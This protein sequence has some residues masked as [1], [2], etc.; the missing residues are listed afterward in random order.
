MG[1][2]RMSEWIDR[3][4]ERFFIWRLKRRGDI[5]ALPHPCVA[6]PTDWARRCIDYSKAPILERTVTGAHNEVLCLWLLLYDDDDY[7]RFCLE[8]TGNSVFV[9]MS[10]GHKV[11]C[12]CRSVE[13]RHTDRFPAAYAE[14]VLDAT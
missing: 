7:E 8:F 14:F 2:D 10:H 9:V 1:D 5:H 13:P 4:L 11:A 12:K 6:G 3:L